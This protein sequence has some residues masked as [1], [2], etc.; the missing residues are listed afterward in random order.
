MAEVND[1]PLEEMDPDDAIARIARE[2]GIPLD[3]ARQV[4]ETTVLGGDVV[5]VDDPDDLDDLD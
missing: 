1:T 2:E 4:Y 5:A 3:A